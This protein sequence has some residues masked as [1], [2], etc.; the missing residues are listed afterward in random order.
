MFISQLMIILLDYRIQREGTTSRWTNYIDGRA[1]TERR[2]TRLKEHRTKK[3]KKRIHNRKK[4]IHCIVMLLCICSHQ[5]RQKVLTLCRALGSKVH[6]NKEKFKTIQ[7]S[8]NIHDRKM[9]D[10]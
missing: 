7:F 8:T 10:L 6:K 5:E 3:K 1:I 2:G 9:T 4:R